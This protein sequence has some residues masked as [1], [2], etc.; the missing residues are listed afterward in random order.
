MPANR[1]VFSR[2]LRDEPKKYCIT[3]VIEGIEEYLVERQLEL[4][5]EKRARLIALLYEHFSETQ[6]EVNQDTIVSYLKLVA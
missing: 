3:R 6:R 2:L 4:K 1:S 5:P